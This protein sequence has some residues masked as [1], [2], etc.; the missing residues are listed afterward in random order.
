M[1]I[2]LQRI[3]GIILA[4]HG[5]IRIVFMET[6][7]AFMR[8]Q[9]EVFL[10]TGSGLTIV[11]SLLLF[12]EFFVGTLLVFDVF[13]KQALFVG[14]VISLLMVFSF[15]GADQYHANLFYYIPITLFLAF[16]FFWKRHSETKRARSGIEMSS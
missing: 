2:R 10:A 12:A 1:P 8:D 13:P 3:I 14:F 15:I 4:V 16:Q 11:A 9:L 7:I 6:H 5:L